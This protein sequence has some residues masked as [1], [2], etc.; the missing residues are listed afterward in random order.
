M[1]SQTT[2]LRTAFPISQPLSLHRSFLFHCYCSGIL[3]AHSPRGAAHGE[4][5]Q[6]DQ[7]HTEAE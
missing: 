5:R 4:F 2:K 3:T 6:L 7:I 1:G